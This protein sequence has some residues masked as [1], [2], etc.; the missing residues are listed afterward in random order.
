MTIRHVQSA[1]HSQE[2]KGTRVVCTSFAASSVNINFCLVNI[3]SL[4]DSSTSMSP[5]LRPNLT[6]FHMHAHSKSIPAHVNLPHEML[7]EGFAAKMNFRK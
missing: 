4:Y 2:A 1:S 6:Q 5:A 3:L 7:R